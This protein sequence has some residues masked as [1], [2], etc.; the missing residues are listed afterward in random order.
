MRRIVTPEGRLQRIGSV[1]AC[2]PF[3]GDFTSCFGQSSTLQAGS[4]APSGLIHHTGPSNSGYVEL[5]TAY[6]RVADEC[7][8]RLGTTMETFE[9]TTR[10]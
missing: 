8:V 7:V 3:S 1:Q 9:H 2:M 6:P 4:G 10:P 5:A